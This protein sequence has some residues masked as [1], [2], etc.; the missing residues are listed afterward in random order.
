MTVAVSN[1]SMKMVPLQSF[2]IELLMSSSLTRLLIKH[3]LTK[4]VPTLF[5]IN[6]IL[7]FSDDK[8]SIDDPG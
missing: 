5:A 6:T 7:W 2:H 3:S 1:G 4:I 8:D